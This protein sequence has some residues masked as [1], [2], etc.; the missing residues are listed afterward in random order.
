MFYYSEISKQAG[1]GEDG[2]CR[3]WRSSSW[4][5]AQ[6]HHSSGRRAA[7]TADHV[8]THAATGEEG[9]RDESRCALRDGRHSVSAHGETGS[10]LDH[11]V[12]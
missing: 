7:G 2:E 10:T 11:T 9:A 3:R 8:Q 4:T 1:A 6:V 5:C 12:G